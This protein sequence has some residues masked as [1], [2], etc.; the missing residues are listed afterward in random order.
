MKL[1]HDIVATDFYN[2]LLIPK[3]KQLFVVH[4]K[5]PIYD[6]IEKES[7]K[8]HRVITNNYLEEIINRVK[9]GFNDSVQI[10]V[11]NKKEVD[12]LKKL[13]KYSVIISTK[14]VASSITID[15]GYSYQHYYHIIKDF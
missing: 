8:I 6:I 12:K 13:K 7:P 1:N 10:L 14:P 4:D 2:Y 15:C 9:V 5:L 11:S 3:T